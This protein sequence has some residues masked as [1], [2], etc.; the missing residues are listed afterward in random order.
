MTVR[1]LDT[2]PAPLVAAIDEAY[3]AV[4]SRHPLSGERW[5]ILVEAGEAGDLFL[6]G[7]IDGQATIELARLLREARRRVEQPLP[8]DVH[9]IELF[10]AADPFAPGF[11]SSPPDAWLVCG[12]PEASVEVKSV[13]GRDAEVARRVRRIVELATYARASR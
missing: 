9:V 4:A 10:H 3:C 2:A 13:E 6:G 7:D 11:F 1:V 5:E 8:K 12:G